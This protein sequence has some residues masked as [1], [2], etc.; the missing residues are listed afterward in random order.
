MNQENKELIVDYQITSSESSINYSDQESK[1]DT[2]RD[3][4]ITTLPDIQHVLNQIKL[5]NVEEI[6]KD[7]IAFVIQGEPSMFQSL[8][9]QGDGTPHL[10]ILENK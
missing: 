7:Q 9:T 2:M 4:L 8:S 5:K 6:N 3:E 1:M 10:D